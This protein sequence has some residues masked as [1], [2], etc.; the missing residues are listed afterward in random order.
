MNTDIDIFQMTAARQ[1]DPDKGAEVIMKRRQIQTAAAK[2]KWMPRWL[3][4]CGTIVVLTVM[5]ILG[6]RT[7]SN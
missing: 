5:G 4:A 3:F 6:I 1:L 7:N 2:P